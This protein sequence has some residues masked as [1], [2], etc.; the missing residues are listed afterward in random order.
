LEHFDGSYEG[1][2]HDWEDE[3][4]ERKFVT[5]CLYGLCA[6]WNLVEKCGYNGTR[7]VV[8]TGGFYPLLHIIL[9]LVP[10]YWKWWPIVNNLIFLAGFIYWYMKWI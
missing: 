6:L 9:A 5:I 1:D 7:F 10:I 4:W 2:E 3:F 8:Q